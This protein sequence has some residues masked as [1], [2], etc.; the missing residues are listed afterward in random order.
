[1]AGVLQSNKLGCSVRQC[2]TAVPHGDVCLGWCCLKHALHSPV[3]LLHYDLVP[4]QASA[5]TRC[6]ILP[7]CVQTWPQESGSHA[8]AAAYLSW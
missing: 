7:T 1:M 6:R 8:Q 3:G 4:L 5:L 2:F